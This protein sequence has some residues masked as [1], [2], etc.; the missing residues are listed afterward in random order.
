MNASKLAA[1]AYRGEIN[2]LDALWGVIDRMREEIE[3]KTDAFGKQ[4]EWISNPVNKVE[5]FADRWND[6]GSVRRENFYRWLDKVKGELLYTQSQNGPGKIFESLKKSFGDAPVTKAF[7][8]I[9]EQSR[10]LNAQGTNNYDRQ[11]RVVGAVDYF[12]IYY[13]LNI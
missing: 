1:R 10:I 6:E 13:L 11:R 8:Q 3:W 12:V 9:G 5:N 7:S 2:V 4:Y